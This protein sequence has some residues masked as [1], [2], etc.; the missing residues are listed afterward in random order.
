MIQAGS[1]K[2]VIFDLLPFVLTALIHRH[3]EIYFKRDVSDPRV[4]YIQSLI[5]KKGKD[6]GQTRLNFTLNVI[7]F[8]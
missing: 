5:E 1:R 6:T 2:D 3:L 4:Y 7:V 8:V